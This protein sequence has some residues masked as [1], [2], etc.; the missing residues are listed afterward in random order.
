MDPDSLVS[1]ESAYP[2][3]TKN[4]TDPRVFWPPGSE[5]TSQMYGSGPDPALDPFI[6][7]Q[8]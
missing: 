2:I 8:K 3:R 1:Y 4:V 7:M 6:I 5:S